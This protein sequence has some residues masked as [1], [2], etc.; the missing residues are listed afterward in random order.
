MAKASCLCGAVR[1]ELEGPFKWMTHCHCSRCRKSHGTAYAT[2]VA[3]PASGYRLHGEEHVVTWQSSSG[4]PR[5]FCGQCGSVVPGGAHGNLMFVPAGNFEDDVALKP[6]AHIFVASK[7]PWFEIHDTLPRFD[8]YPP[9]FDAPSLPDRA[10]LDPPGKAR[11]SCLCGSVTF[12]VEGDL[13]RCWSCHCGRCR[14][15]KSGAFSTHFV[16]RADGV[17]YTRGRELVREFKVPEAKHFRQAFCGTCGSVTPRIDP[18]RD[19][20]LVPMGSFDDDPVARPTAHIF[21]GSKAPWDV[22]AD[23]LPQHAEY[24]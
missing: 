3:G 2:Y 15:G 8:A 18:E 14:R 1:W 22:I 6:E 19:L 11:G 23:G 7:A 12:V 17:H 4:V 10:P 20:G 13:V 21:V 24:P 5:S 16:T 9:G